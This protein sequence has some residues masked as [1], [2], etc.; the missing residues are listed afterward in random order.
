M[1]EAN[2]KVQ[3]NIEDLFEEEEDFGKLLDAYDKSKEEAIF[4]GKI[5]AIKNDEVYVDI[6]KKSEGLLALEEIQDDKGNLIFNVG[7]S[8][9]VATMGSRGGRIV[10]SHKKALRKE[11]VVEFIK[12]YNEENE[13]IFDVK[14]ISKN[15]GGLVAVD[16]D[17]VEFF[18]PKSQYG[19]KDSNNPIGKNFKVKIIKVDKEEQSIVASRKR[20]LEDER[21]KR[22]E[23]ISEI[24]DKNELIEGL[25]KKITTY[26]M[27]VDVG[28][29]DGLV[30]YSEI[31]YKGPVNPSSLYKEGDK[32]PVKIIKYDKD[33]KHLSLSIKAALPDPWSEIK[34]SL[35]VGDTIKVVVSNIEPYGAFVDLGN[36]IEGFLHISEISWNKNIKNPKDYISK[37]EEIDVEV[38]EINSDERRLRVSLRNLLSKPFDEFS[39]TH[40]VGDMTQGI[41]TS[42]TAFGA[43]VKI[44]NVEG[45]LHN[46]DASW[47]RNDKCKELFKIGD[48]IK[49]KIIKIDEDNQKISLST[50][51][52][53]NSPV[54][55]YAKTHK[56]GDVVKGM[57]RDIKDFGIFVE[58][59]ENV[60]ALIHKEDISSAMLETLK[61]DDEIEA[62]IAF[63][64]EKKN[65]IRLSVKNLLKLKE[66]EVLNEINGDDKMTLGD[67]IKEQLS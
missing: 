17:G 40:K 50:K 49:V 39:K 57:I 42:I 28:G 11:K 52:L 62:A 29:I 38:I 30:H 41:V 35:E 55:E 9:K 56:V 25:V 31:S 48:E 45:L 53:K 3:N 37:G 6:G 61:I 20:V 10:V 13:N 8:I 16:N 43:F 4:E 14:V 22:K 19:F 15:K 65:R 2:K 51:E 67:I 27:F 21:K 24:L 54:Q 33:K 34:D 63:I 23:I 64:D 46:E 59:S 44:D 5:V 58:L 26:G 32:V 66:R 36:D 12:N 1:N 18:I 47:D 60:D 7:D